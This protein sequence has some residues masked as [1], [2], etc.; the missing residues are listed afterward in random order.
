M[1]SLLG[2]R[3]G[4]VRLSLPFWLKDGHPSL[5][6][7]PT[8]NLS[9]LPFVSDRLNRVHGTNREHPLNPWV[10]NLMVNNCFVPAALLGKPAGR[11]VGPGRSRLTR[12]KSK[13][14]GER[15]PLDDDEDAKQD[16]VFK[17]LTK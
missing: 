3:V 11:R 4:E 2:G 10:T 9:V 1:L 6:F 12:Y 14:V 17:P 15:F 5:F 8:L 7:P 13:A 16:K